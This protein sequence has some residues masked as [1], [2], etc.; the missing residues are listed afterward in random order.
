MVDA[1]KFLR[2]FYTTRGDILTK[3]HKKRSVIAKLIRTPL[4]FQFFQ[5]SEFVQRMRSPTLK[6]PQFSSQMSASRQPTAGLFC[7]RFATTAK[8]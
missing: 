5:S 7:V 2:N 1:G 8:S 6:N 4:V 3:F